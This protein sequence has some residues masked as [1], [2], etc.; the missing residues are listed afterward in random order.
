MA[1]LVE[2]PTPT[3]RPAVVDGRLVWLPL[4]PGLLRGERAFAAPGERSLWNA[5]L[6]SALAERAFEQL[7]AVSD[8]TQLFDPST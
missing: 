4:L 3:R 6:A 1:P 2:V 8:V 5:V 7:D